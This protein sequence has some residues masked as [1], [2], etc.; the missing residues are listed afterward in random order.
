[1]EDF[2]REAKR[3][4]ARRNTVNQHRR[5]SGNGTPRISSHS[6]WSKVS[7]EKLNGFVRV[8]GA[9]EHNLKNVR[10]RYSARC[11]GGVHRCL[12]FGQIVPGLRHS[13]CR[14]AAAISGIRLAV[15]QAAVSSDGS[16]RGGQHRR[17]AA[18]GGAAA[19]TR[20]AD[21]AL[22]GRQRHHAVEPPAH[23]VFARRR[24]SARP[25]DCFMPNLFRRTRPREP[26]PS[27]MGWAGSMK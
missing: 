18:G 9:R 25:A 5:L 17:S 22:V 3:Y 27:V 1:M 21:H 26:A 11:P 12:G 6:E 20:I 14:S 13:L 19:T 2:L 23:A 16:A 10:P 4:H 7:S 24:V 15:C 8:R